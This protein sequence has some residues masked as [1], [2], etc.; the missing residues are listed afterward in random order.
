MLTITF[1]ERRT[2]RLRLC[3]LHA[4]GVHKDLADPL[5]AYLHCTGVTEGPII[6]TPGKPPER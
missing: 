4:E 1:A 6:A 2:Q 3:E 5:F